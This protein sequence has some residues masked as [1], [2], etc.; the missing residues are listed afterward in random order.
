MADT[1]RAAVAKDLQALIERRIE[2]RS[3][4]KG[5]AYR[6]GYAMIK[7]AKPGIVERAI[8]KLYPL[9]MAQLDPLHAEANKAGKPFADHLGRNSERAAKALLALAEQRVAMSSETVQKFY[10]KFRGGA[11]EE[12]AAAMPELGTLLARHIA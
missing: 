8:E 11:E 10:A 9:Y 12:V 2:G 5:M 4:L 1:R 6:A 7:K 3:G